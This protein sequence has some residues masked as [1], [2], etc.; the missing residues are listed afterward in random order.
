MDK[1]IARAIEEFSLCL[2]DIGIHPERIIVFG[3]HA[4]GAAQEHSDIDLAVV[5]DDFEGMNIF[6]RLEIIGVALA[7]AKIME[8]IEALAYTQREY[9]SREPGTFLS[10]EINAK[11]VQ[12]I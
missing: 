5:S 9:D 7:R 11:G 4:T 2:Q 3:S 6:R 10:D 8:P 12:V 1:K